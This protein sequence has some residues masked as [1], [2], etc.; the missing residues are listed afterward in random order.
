M[1][2][3]CWSRSDAAFVV[4]RHRRWRSRLVL[5]ESPA[6]A[7]CG[8]RGAAPMRNLL[9]F[10]SMRNLLETSREVKQLRDSE[11]NI[12]ARL[13]L[14]RFHP[15]QLADTTDKVVGDKHRNYKPRRPHLH[16]SSVT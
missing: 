5:P 13:T 16:L 1:A 9:K 7:P 12:R 2:R 8:G 6:W 15:R 4:W 14:L 10:L 11:E 3:R